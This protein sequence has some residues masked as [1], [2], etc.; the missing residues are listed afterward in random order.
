MI[1]LDQ[2]NKDRLKA[3][4]EL[5]KAGVLC[6]HCRTEMHYTTGVVLPSMPPKKEVACSKCGYTGYKVQ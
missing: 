6:D 1:T 5:N 4:A 3:I 2:H